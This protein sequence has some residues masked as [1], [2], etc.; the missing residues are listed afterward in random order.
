VKRE[1]W[2]YLPVVFPYVLRYKA[3]A[4]ATAVLTVLGAVLALAEPWPLAL[5]I[6]G[7]LGSQHVPGYV[8]AV[9]GS[10][11][12]GLIVVAVVAGF[13]ITLLAQVVGVAN[14]YATTKLDQQVSFDFRSDLFA[15]CQQLSQGFHD[16]TTIGDS[17]YRINFEA[18][19]VG[20]MSVA[21]APLAQS[22]LTLV[23]MFVVACEIDLQ[24]ALISLVA[25]PFVYYS[26]GYYGKNV[27]P[28]LIAVRTLEAR[29][30]TMVNDAFSMLR[31]VTAFNRQDHEHGLFREQ[32]AEA[33]DAR[34][35]LTVRQTLFSMVVALSTA[36][37]IALIL[38]FGA[39]AVIDHRITVGALTVILAYVHS[40]YSPLEAISSTMG[41]FQEHLISIRYAQELLLSEPEVTDAPD[42]V[43]LED[44]NGGVEVRDVSFA[45]RG[46]PDALTG[47]SFTV[48]AGEAVGVVGPTGAG[49]STLMSLL[50]RFVDPSSGAV[51]IDGK[52]VRGLT[53]RSV[54]DRISIVH[55]EALLF[56]RSIRENIRYGRIDATD[57]EIEAAARAANAHD[58]ISALPRGYD[59]ELG[60]RGA[61]VS[62]GERQRLAMARAFLK[63]AP[64]LILDEP[65]SSIDSQTE[66]VILDALDRLMVGRT[67]FIV[68]HR[69]STLR[70]ADRI[71]V[72]DHG[73]L[74]QSG[75]RDELL[76]DEG[77]YRIL[78]DLQSGVTPSASQPAGSDSAAADG[79][80]SDSVAADGA[81]SVGSGSDGAVPAGPPPPTP[82]S[83]APGGVWVPPPPPI[84]RP[85]SNAVLTRG[86]NTDVR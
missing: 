84:F 68:A 73:R 16:Q 77:L 56:P 10:S 52:D 19:A 54:R 63:D 44:V 28:R 51:L 30:L 33:V 2:K 31:V 83:P 13:V 41:V 61:T 25:V 27:E 38:G 45:Y 26:T 12:S 62:G 70:R 49:K 22:V 72:L 66:A 23:G 37:G 15:H 35:R 47:V 75:T 50:P 82:G 1:Y 64:I 34:V 42:A 74:I 40:M 59:T 43:D 17:M 20:Q 80:T 8:A 55:Q 79:A 46:R 81:G 58:F 5:L 7:V 14:E 78:H 6:D 3:L 18:K 48:A 53:L 67:T 39:H 86:V 69:L 71:L 85:A 57:A 24:L 9:G 29:S 65:T 4:A 36:A 76:A 32:G 11:R 60:E 21:L